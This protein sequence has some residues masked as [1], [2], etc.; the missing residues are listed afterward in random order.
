[1]NLQFTSTGSHLAQAEGPWKMERNY[2]YIDSKNKES[3]TFSTINAGNIREHLLTLTANARML[4][5]FKSYNSDRFL[6]TYSKI[7]Y[8]EEYAEPVSEL[9]R[10]FFNAYWNQKKCDLD[11]FERQYIF[12]DLRYKQAIKQLSEKFYEPVDMNPLEDYKW[13]QLTNRTFRIEPGDENANNQIEAILSGTKRS[14]QHFKKVAIASDSIYHMLDKEKRVFFNDNLRSVSYFMMYLNES[15][16]QYCLAYKSESQI[17]RADCLKKALN[18]ALNARESI[19]ESA[20]DQFEGWYSQEKIFGM[21]DY[22][23]RISKTKNY[24]FNL[25]NNN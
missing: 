5:N 1:M 12:H 25:A 3:F 14:Y 21:D 8:G 20:H 11:G 24:I 16:H 7:Y 22:I 17:E 9:Y 18:A 23:S 19:C 15:L 10:D 6:K 2:K 13:E 4:W